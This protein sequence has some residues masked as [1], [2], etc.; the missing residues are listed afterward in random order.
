MTG[1]LAS[2]R[3]RTIRCPG[4]FGEPSSLLGSPLGREIENRL[5]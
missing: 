4:A 3:R 1:Y 2:R 5:S